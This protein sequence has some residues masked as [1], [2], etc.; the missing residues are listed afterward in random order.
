MDN[1][2][3]NYLGVSIIGAIVLLTISMIWY[4]WAFSDSASPQRSFQVQ[5]EG[6]VVAVPDVA[7]ISFGVTTEGGKN[8]ADLQK[9][10]SEKANK[11]IAFLKQ[12]GVDGKDIKTQYYNISPRYQ[13][14][15]CPIAESRAEPCPPSEIVGY[16][17][18]QS[19]SVK[20][21]ELG[22]TGDIL[23]GVAENGANTVSGP[24][25]TIDDPTE[26]QNQARA[27]AI[28]KAKEKARA[29]AKAGGFRLGKISSI[30]EGISYP[31]PIM[32]EAA[33]LGKGGAAPSIEPGSQEVTVNVT[34]IY[35]IK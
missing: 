27:A 10:N 25:F 18:S 9:E 29:V 1:K 24:S 13:Y 34:I 6:K 32:F 31:I 20:V 23:A 5:G 33:A 3:K 26:L 22:K 21:R 28:A 15:S 16:T 14:Y 35:E 8:I 11:V 4:V 30:Q 7:E 2:I 17:I 19:V 12:S